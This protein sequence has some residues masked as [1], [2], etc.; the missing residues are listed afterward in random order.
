MLLA[1]NVTINLLC[2]ILLLV[3]IILIFLPQVQRHEKKCSELEAQLKTS[4]SSTAE[5][6]SRLVSSLRKM[7]EEVKRVKREREE[8]VVKMRREEEGME[9]AHHHELQ[10]AVHRIEEEEQK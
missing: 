5:E 7:E 3:S 1:S 9:K 10:M 6:R 8:D 2:I 4:E